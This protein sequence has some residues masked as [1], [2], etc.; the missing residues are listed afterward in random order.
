M[1]IAVPIILLVPLALAA[2]ATSPTAQVRNARVQRDVKACVA[3]KW[4]S[5][6]MYW[7]GPFYG[8]AGPFATPGG[9]SARLHVNRQPGIAPEVPRIGHI[10]RQCQ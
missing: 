5:H 1:K 7:R 6:G 2:C 4:L 9:R 8:P 3:D 10:E